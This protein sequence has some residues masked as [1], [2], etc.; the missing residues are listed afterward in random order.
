MLIP[1]SPSEQ[2]L[3]TTVKIDVRNSSGSGVGTG[4]FFDVPFDA[5]R[6]IPVIVTNKHVIDGAEEGE[7]LIHRA[8]E[9]EGQQ[10]PSGVV[11]RV[12][13]KDFERRWTPHPSPNVDLCCLPIGGIHQE[14]QTRGWNPFYRS[15]SDDLIWDDARLLREFGAVEDVLMIG[16]PTG[17]WDFANN[18]PLVR[19]GITASHP[20]IDYCGSATTVVDIASFPGSSGSPVFHLKEGGYTDKKGNTI[21]GAPRFV[22]FG[23]L[24]EGP[25]WTADGVLLKKRPIPTT[26]ETPVMMHLGHI[27]KAKEL[28]ILSDSVR[29]RLKR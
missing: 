28:R 7:F 27:V 15:V 23:V 3:F 25:T 11:E 12:V 26:A 14:A 8:V 17:L 1:E 21:M 16:Y 13:V 20:G 24:S 2:L 29:R 9:R 6:H 5:D 18:L 4:F 22:F 19:K 10:V